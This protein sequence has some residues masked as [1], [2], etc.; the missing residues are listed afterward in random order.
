MGWYFAVLVIAVDV[1]SRVP[2]E[3][4]LRFSARE[5]AS[6]RSQGEHL[7]GEIEGIRWLLSSL[8]VGR[9]KVLTSPDAS[10]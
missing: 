2:R 10:V 4:N 6:L 9:Q 3:S 5:V 1:E 7:S 8:P